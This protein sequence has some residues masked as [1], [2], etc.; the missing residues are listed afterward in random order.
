MVDE[1]AREATADCDGPDGNAAAV[2]ALGVPLTLA[3]CDGNADTTGSGDAPGVPLTPEA[4]DDAT[5]ADD[6]P[7]VPLALAAS[8]GNADDT[9]GTGDAVD[10]PPTPAACDGNAGGTTAAGDAPEVAPELW[11]DP[12]GVAAAVGDSGAGEPLGDATSVGEGI[13]RVAGTPTVAG[14]VGLAGGVDG[15]AGDGSTFDEGPAVGVILGTALCAGMR[16]VAEGAVEGVEAIAAACGTPTAGAADGF[17][18]TGPA[19]AVPGGTDAVATR[20]E[21]EEDARALSV[22]NSRSC[23]PGPRKGNAGGVR[24]DAASRAR[25]GCGGG[26][27]AQVV[28]VTAAAQAMPATDNRQD[29]GRRRRCFAW[30]RIRDR[31]PFIPLSDGLEPP[32][33]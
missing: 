13:S 3:A 25:S 17:S 14:A 31:L 4:S 26:R 24:T 10:V 9:T 1:T 22:R 32:R 30:L 21:G 2:D 16:L 20:R 8:D 29:R 18:D 23:P 28:P 27:S 6:T 15:D 19:A 12:T 7:D 5:A 33:R 11:P